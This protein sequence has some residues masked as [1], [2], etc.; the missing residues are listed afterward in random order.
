MEIIQASFLVDWYTDTQQEKR[1][2][3]RQEQ[4]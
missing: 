4:Q 1:D 3:E 2:Q